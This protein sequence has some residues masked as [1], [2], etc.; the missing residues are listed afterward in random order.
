MPT[1]WAE[2]DPLSRP[3]ERV[4]LVIRELSPVRGILVYAS[5]YLGVL[6][7]KRRA[8]RSSQI[9]PDS[10]CFSAGGK[11]A[12]SMVSSWLTIIVVPS[13]RHDLHSGKYLS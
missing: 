5:R 13:L 12:L 3:A 10:P 6:E 7:N 1:G 4:E 11:A 8:G 9:L 2:A